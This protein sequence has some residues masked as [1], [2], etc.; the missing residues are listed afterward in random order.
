[1]KALRDRSKALAQG[2]AAIR[3]QYHLPQAFPPAVIT[4][5]ED[6]AKRNFPAHRD[7]TDQAFV[8]LD[9]L[10]STDLDQA[11]AIEASG[12]DLLLHYAIADVASFVES[13]GAID[14]EAWERG[15]TVY[16]PDGKVGLYP[17]V[18]SE[19]AASLLPDGPR[20]AVVFT[21]RVDPTGGVKLDAVERAMIRSRAK[22]G[23]A[24]VTPDQLP[25]G[26]F[27]LARRI[28][29]N[30]SARG[31]SRVDPPQ[32]EVEEL[33]DGSFALQ[34]R[35]VSQAEIANA[36]L[37]LAA[38]MAIA[39]TLL[40]HHTGLFRVMPD[41]DKRARRRIAESA[42]ALGINWPKE[43]SL[44]DLQRRLDPNDK[45]QAAL[46]LAIRRSGAHASYESYREGERPWHWAMAA[47]YVHAT[48][49]LRRLADR[50]VIE[51]AY[52]VA[53]GQAV[54]DAVTEAFQQLPAVMAKADAKAAQ[55][56]AAA[57]DLAEAVELQ[58]RI[59]QL[60][61]GQVTDVD[62]RG[63]RVQLCGEAIIIRVPLAAPQI[64]DRVR[65]KLVASDPALRKTQFV[66]A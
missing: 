38:N 3:D 52:A 47:T 7:R 61:D 53:N 1:L 5:A 18:L 27:E 51:A 45:A 12:A 17:P 19:G 64:G 56:G 13:G 42:K 40:A 35:A 20:S 33:P 4:E 28:A 62:Q 2:L 31:A 15:E 36:A 49:P 63:A 44:H 43:E 55:V 34:F 25:S 59:G 48:A 65:L 29:A 16:L 46:M 23:Y 11:F 66:L 41:P 57:V 8:T 39:D 10:S 30:E 37:S 21:V 26:F 6:A 14:R 60:F 9:P 32:Q 58:S 22:L 24:T 54:P 50:Y